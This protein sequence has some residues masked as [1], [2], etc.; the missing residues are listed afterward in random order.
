MNRIITSYSQFPLRWRLLWALQQLIRSTPFS[1]LSF[2][3][4]CPSC[5]RHSITVTRRPTRTMYE[6]P[7]S[8]FEISCIDCF[9]EHDDYWRERW[10]DYYAGLL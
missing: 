2:F 9:E 3:N 8:N 4:I 5:L 10:D 7:E 6:D 1:I